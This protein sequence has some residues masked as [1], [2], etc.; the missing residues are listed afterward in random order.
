MSKKKK[1]WMS[2]KHWRYETSEN[3]ILEKTIH[4]THPQTPAVFLK[5]NL[6]YQLHQGGS[7]MTIHMFPT[8]DSS[9]GG[10]IKLVPGFSFK[11]NRKAR[12][13]PGQLA[14]LLNH[15]YFDWDWRFFLDSEWWKLTVSKTSGNLMG[16]KLEDCFPGWDGLF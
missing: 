16:W 14:D 15:W 5:K 8:H 11:K 1:A 13:N 7:H 10:F 12:K 6:A 4:E 9:R 2:R 3:K